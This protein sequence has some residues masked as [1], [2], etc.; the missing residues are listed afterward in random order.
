MFRWAS[1]ALL[2]VLLVL[3][4][5]GP[6]QSDIVLL[7]VGKSNVSLGE[8]ESFF[9]RNSG[10]WEVAKQSSLEERER[11]LDLL[12]NYKLKLQYAY[13]NNLQKDPEITSELADYRTSL[14]STFLIEK[15]ITE[16][17]TVQLYNRKKEEIRASHI[18]FQVKPDA[19][20][21]DTLKAFEKALDIL[22]RLKAG[23]PFETLAVRYS[24]D[25][26]AKFNKGDLYYFTGGQMTPPFENVAYALKVG[27]VAPR[28]VRSGFGYHVIKLTGRQPSRGKIKAGHIMM[29]FQTSAADSADTTNALV[30][31][32]GV[33]DSL[34]KGMQ[35]ADL[36]AK[37][38]E[39]QGSA[40]QGGSL[41]WFERRRWIQPFDEVAFTLT[42]GQTSGVVRTPYGYHIIHCDSVQP[43]PPYGEIREEVRKRYQETRYNDDY[44]AFIANLK[45]DY[46]YAFDDAVFHE[47]LASIDTN[48]TTDDSGWAGTIPAALRSRMLMSI[49]NSPISLDSFIT[50]VSTKQDFRGTILREKELRNRADKY[51][52]ILLLDT[53]SAGL[54]ASYP[55]FAALMKEYQDGVVLFKA[56]QMEVWNKVAVN[57]TALREYFNANKDK[58]RFPARVDYSEL[59]VESDT[60]ALL[61]YDSLSSGGDFAAFAARYNEDEE[62]K[63]KGGSHGFQPVD[64]DDLA[65]EAETMEI[66]KISEPIEIETGGYVII[67][68]NGKEPARPKTFEEAGA[69]V[70]NAFQE[71]ESKRLEKLWLERIQQQHPVVMFKEHLN[72]AFTHQPEQP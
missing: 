36:A 10:G 28:P 51:G 8:Y 41:G 58:F 39:D 6:K 65:A 66:G 46:A 50:V 56:E 52:E 22:T 59:R 53:R 54:E 31:I 64:S 13:D 61:V 42:A 47:F 23:E 19:S 1:S 40:P 5:C 34:R 32:N 44:M 49:K 55:E 3:V 11:F 68:T 24:E 29:R 69:E 71:Y 27:E 62:L 7:Q 18:L 15:E 35:F 67:R 2:I 48:Q 30:R 12:K 9:M 70:S 20:P 33:L 14:A 60:L 45:K 17:G 43:F 37:L 57:D 16:P 26:S 63:A 72:E 25:P 21:E 38:S 4:G